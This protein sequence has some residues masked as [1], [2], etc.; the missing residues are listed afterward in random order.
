MLSFLL[1]YIT[2]N[3]K[4]LRTLAYQDDHPDLNY[5][6]TVYKKEFVKY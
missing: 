2:N 3:E 5:Y 4:S 1:K 6:K